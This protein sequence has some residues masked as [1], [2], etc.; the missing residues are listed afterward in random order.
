MHGGEYFPGREDDEILSEG[1]TVG[2]YRND[3]LLSDRA[4]ELLDQ[5]KTAG[6]GNREAL[7]NEAQNLISQIQSEPMRRRMQ[8]I[9]QYGDVSVP[10]T[11]PA[12]IPEPEQ[13]VEVIP[14]IDIPIE[15]AAPSGP[16]SDTSIGNEAPSG[17]AGP[18]SE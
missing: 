14:E 1:Y 18:A 16:G 7:R 4:E 15:P 11:P 3:R 13:P 9:L 12:Q 10:V 6:G 17:P 2:D 5:M 8:D